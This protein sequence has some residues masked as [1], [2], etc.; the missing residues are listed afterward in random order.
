MIPRLLIKQFNKKTNEYNKGYYSNSIK[1][2]VYNH[3]EF[4][5]L[6]DSK[7]SIEVQNY[8]YKT[9]VWIPSHTF[10]IDKDFKPKF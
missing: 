7:Y 6:D 3:M 9:G 5:K 10:I 8:C 2:E 4:A 1:Q